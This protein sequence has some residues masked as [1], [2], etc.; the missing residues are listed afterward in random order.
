MPTPSMPEKSYKKVLPISEQ[1]KALD[2]KESCTETAKIYGKN[3]ASV[4]L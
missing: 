3:E 2:L 1:V 4:K